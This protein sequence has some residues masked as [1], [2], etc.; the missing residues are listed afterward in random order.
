MIKGKIRDNREKNETHGSKD[1]NGELK[2]PV[3]YTH[4]CPLFTYC[5]V[6]VERKEREKKIFMSI[7]KET[8]TF[9][10]RKEEK[11]ALKPGKKRKNDV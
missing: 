2:G 11:I 6:D 3:K 4:N 9:D 7:K 5:V 10:S 8:P 1:K